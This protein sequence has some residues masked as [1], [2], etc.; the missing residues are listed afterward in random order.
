MF[1]SSVEQIIKCFIIR[2]ITFSCIT[3]RIWWKLMIRNLSVLS[4]FF[5]CSGTENKKESSTPQSH[6]VVFC[7]YVAIP[8]PKPERQEFSPQYVILKIILK[9]CIGSLDISV[10]LVLLPLHWLFFF[11]LNRRRAL[12]K[13][14][15]HAVSSKLHKPPW[16]DF[17]ESHYK[18]LE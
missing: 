9:S 8:F 1:H 2:F 10:L 6:K 7:L 13:I 12:A 11:F 17:A 4:S 15:L 3:L 14:M 5:C 16:K 18:S